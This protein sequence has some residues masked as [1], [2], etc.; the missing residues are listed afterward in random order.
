MLTN[1]VIRDYFKCE[2]KAYAKQQDQVGTISEFETLENKISEVIKERY[3]S[4]LLLDKKTVL[5]DF[6]LKKIILPFTEIYVVNPRLKT[7]DLDISFDAI[8]IINKSHEN[9][10]SHD[11][12]C[13]PIEIL[14]RKKITA[15]DKLVLAIK[16]LI[17]SQYCNL[18]IETGQIIHAYSM[19]RVNIK[20]ISYLKN[21]QKHLKKILSLINNK[22]P[23][24]LYWIEHCKVCEFQKFCKDKLLERDD[25][26]LLSSINK[27]DAIK[28]KN[29]GIFTILQLSYTFK[30][31]KREKLDSECTK[32]DASLKALA[33][34]DQKVYVKELPNI[35]TYE[36]EVYLDFEGIPD[37]NFIYLI[38][39]LIITNNKEN[40]I[41]SWIDSKDQQEDLFKW[42]FDILKIY[43]YLHIFHYG[44]Y[45]IKA[46]DKFNK[47]SGNFLLQ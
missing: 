24:D 3:Y 2:Y 33:L 47:C 27:K 26:S 14:P 20:L 11:C 10:L 25:I 43:E 41:Y 4:Q 19:S 42:L 37:E 31:K 28:W 34:R 15:N 35:K 22:V 39:A 9:E 46:L 44:N 18:Q 45:E 12:I 21:A 40:Y 7:K 1:S 38:G 32:T 13:C 6:D 30:P 5:N 29:K 16:C 17:F 23:P 8:K 36:T